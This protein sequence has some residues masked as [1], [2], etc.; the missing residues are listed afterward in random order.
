MILLGRN[1]RG[2]LETK[3]NNQT[4]R[5]DRVRDRKRIETEFKVRRNFGIIHP[6]T[7]EHP[8][9]PSRERPPLDLQS[10]RGQ[11]KSMKQSHQSPT[12]HPP[13]NRPTDRQTQI[14]KIFQ[15]DTNT[16]TNHCGT[17]YPDC[18]PLQK[19]HIPRRKGISQHRHTDH[20]RP[21]Q[22]DHRKY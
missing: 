21:H 14:H 9:S 5:T 22:L 20:H 1:I 8:L 18:H 11:P 7:D 15:L 6:H 3:W 2:H 16:S 13:T 17:A 10:Y 12:S 19:T 4:P